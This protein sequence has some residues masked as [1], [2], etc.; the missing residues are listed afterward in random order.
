MDTTL[1][2]LLLLLSSS[3]FG[4]NHK[5]ASWGGHHFTPPPLS[6]TTLSLSLQNTAPPHPHPLSP[7]FP[8]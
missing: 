2:Q 1:P 4:V 5:R 3:G 6:V 8:V 7:V